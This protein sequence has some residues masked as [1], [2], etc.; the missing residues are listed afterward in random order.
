MN[1]QPLCY[2][3]SRQKIWKINCRYLLY[4]YKNHFG[5]FHKQKTQR[6]IFLKKL[7]ATNLKPL[8]C[9]KKI[10]D[11]KKFEKF[12]AL[13]FHNTWK[14]SFWAY[15][16]FVLPKKFQNKIFLQKIIY[17][18]FKPLHDCNLYKKSPGHQFFI[19]LKKKTHFG[20]FWSQKPRAR[21]FLKRL[22]KLDA[23]LNSWKKSANFCKRFQRKT[24]NKQANKQ[25]HKQMEDIPCAKKCKRN[26]VGS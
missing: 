9:C 2:C 10:Y 7:I 4:N 15:F 23:T 3:D 22:F 20:S 1:C 6:K 19:K 21:F 16:G 11:A 17:F 13:I 24:S 25:I 14:N 18:K 26:W 8:R 5:S 12:H